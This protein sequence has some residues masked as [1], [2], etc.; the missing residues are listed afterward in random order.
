MIKTPSSHNTYCLCTTSNNTRV[1][2]S[3]ALSGHPSSSS[4]ILMGFST[5]NQPFWGSPICGHPYSMLG[6]HW[7]RLQSLLRE[8]WRCRLPE[9]RHHG[10]EIPGVAGFHPKE[11]NSPMSP[12]SKKKVGTFCTVPGPCM[13]YNIYR[14]R[15]P[16]VKRGKDFR[17]HVGKIMS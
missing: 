5:I 7:K 12:I 4:S 13:R 6:F 9:P 17:S 8:V 15:A 1:A 16:Q 10:A 3:S 14:T 2:S 11:G